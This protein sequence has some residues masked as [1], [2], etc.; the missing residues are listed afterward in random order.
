MKDIKGDWRITN[1]EYDPKDKLQGLQLGK[2]L[3]WIRL[4]RLSQETTDEVSKL[5]F[6]VEFDTEKEKESFID[7]VEKSRDNEEEFP[8]KEMPQVHD[9][10]WTWFS[11]LFW[12]FFSLNGIID[13]CAVLPL[14]I[15][16]GLGESVTTGATV[17]IRVARA[18]RLVRFFRFFDNSTT[19]SLLYVLQHT[20][21]RSLWT[22]LF[23][24]LVFLI[25]SF[26]FAFIIFAFERGTFEVTTEHPNGAYYR[27]N[28]YNN[29]KEES[30]FRSLSTSLYFTIISMTTVGYGDL[31]ATSP[32][33]RF[34][35]NLAALVGILVIALP[36]CVINHHLSQVRQLLCA[37][38][39]LLVSYLHSVPLTMC[40]HTHTQEY[41]KV[42][43]VEEKREEEEKKTLHGN[44]ET[45]VF[46]GVLYSHITPLQAYQGFVSL[47]EA[48]KGVGAAIGTDEGKENTASSL[49]PPLG[50]ENS[51]AENDTV[52]AQVSLKRGPSAETTWAEFLD[53]NIDNA[54][55][56]I[57]GKVNVI[58][59]DEKEKTRQRRSSRIN[60]ESEGLPHSLSTEVVNE[61]NGPLSREGSVS[62]KES[63]AIGEAGVDAEEGGTLKKDEQVVGVAEP[64]S[65]R[66]QLEHLSFRISIE[67]R[68]DVE[69][70]K[71][72]TLR[73]SIASA[74][75][76]GLV[77]NA[78][79]E[80]EKEYGDFFSE[81]IKQSISEIKETHK[82]ASE[83][84]MQAIE[85]TKFLVAHLDAILPPVF[86]EKQ[87]DEEKEKEVQR[88]N[89]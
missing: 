75:L 68:R 76:H 80:L 66:R 13:L 48:R 32:A 39:H 33:G 43:D 70:V 9:Q 83:Q 45:N 73:F 67:Q 41:K 37:N 7:W 89:S 40:T 50:Q 63:A 81:K 30:P 17:F 15:Q 6:N 11:T 56:D 53:M 64:T 19:S 31:V 27:M 42:E 54:E 12:Y 55:K 22:L 51:R 71:R 36:V 3:D 47:F 69:D 84:Q 2:S 77:A 24:L 86:E 57:E 87:N 79:V 4:G 18:F 21:S 58:K 78:I 23:M 59:D 85:A 35:A 26:I 46:G 34:V 10:D 62:R 72:Q 16:L 74:M 65:P 1:S 8:C 52:D 28:P 29:E 61:L 25:L 20:V 82:T 38:T 60:A 49:G 5:G 14:F 88:Q 44:T